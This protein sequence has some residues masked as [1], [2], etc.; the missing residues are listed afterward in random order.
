MELS[1]VKMLNDLEKEKSRLKKMY[2]DVAR[3]N[4]LLKDLFSKKGSYL[5]QK[6]ANTRAG[7]RVRC[8]GEQGLQIEI[9]STFSVLL[10]N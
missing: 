3:D 10:R 7:A 5:P 2:A 1:D 4:Q 9:N 6:T 8:T